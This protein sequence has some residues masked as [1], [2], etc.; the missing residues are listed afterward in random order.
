[1]RAHPPVPEKPRNSPQSGPRHN[2]MPESSKRIIEAIRAFKGPFTHADILAQTRARSGAQ[3][4]SRHGKPS[5]KGGRERPIVDETLRGLTAAGLLLK[6]G[7]SYTRTDGFSPEGVITIDRR[8][9]GTIKTDDGL[10]LGV[11]KENIGNAHSGDLV[12]AE[13]DDIRNEVCYARVTE[14]RRRGKER[15]MARV[16]TKLGDRILLRLVDMPGGVTLRARRSPS[17]PLKGDLCIVRLTGR[18]VSGMAECSVERSFSP[19]D[20]EYDVQRILIKHSIPDR[21]P[22]YEELDAFDKKFLSREKK[23]RR[24]YR[25]LYTVT[26][27]GDNAKDFDDAISF[28]SG[29]NGHRLYIHIADVSTFVKPGG[30]LDMEAARRGTSFYLGNH[31]VPMLPEPLSNELCSLKERVDRLSLTAELVFD[32][33]GKPIS[34]SFH[35]GLIKVDRRLTYSS[36]H[37]MIEGGK[38]GKTDR[39]LLSMYEF[40]MILKQR[41]MRQGRLD[42]N[43]TDSEFIYEG[44]TLVDLI[45]AR[46]FKSHTIIEEFMLSANE[47]V[48][49]ALRENGIPTLYRIHETISQEKLTALK[50]FLQTLSMPL[51]SVG[52]IGAALQEVIESVK[53]RDDEVV[54]NYIILKSLMQAYYGTEPLGHFGLGF[55]DYT[56]FTSP[57]RRYP[58]LV[59]HRCLKTLIERKSPPYS[60]EA[61][62]PVGERSSEMERIAQNAERDLHRLKSCRLM[63]ER[64]GEVFDAVISGISRYG[65][66]VTLMER[67]IEGMVPLRTLTNDYYLVNEDE[68]TVVGRRLG[69]RF[70]LGDRVR[71]RLIGV[72]IE[73]MRIDFEVATAAS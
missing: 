63:R 15:Y 65:F 30:E 50:K 14:V 58:D 13:L 31:V 39:L 53:G 67:P 9:A 19:D 7:R 25:K 17:E 5:N 2:S 32:K 43:L 46:R 4:R 6:R 66:F 44:N 45:A 62:R 55:K 73:T 41:R 42:L 1:L 20:E 22:H 69:R 37:R 18:T 38:R 57:I 48:S 59:V 28:E 61:L 49:K 23:G 3:A 54:V 51:R 26:I 70:R 64:I 47:A 21:H 56:H 36:A 72:E 27:D 24:D 8:G 12:K 71:V 10:T 34:Q 16:E 11:L 33:S 52:N 29:H 68:F 60:V 35:R 40:A